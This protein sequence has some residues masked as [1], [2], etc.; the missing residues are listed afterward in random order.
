MATQSEVLAKFGE[1]YKALPNYPASD[2]P[3]R[4]V[5]A[6]ALVVLEKMKKTISLDLNDFLAASK[7]QISGVSA[8]AVQ[9]I[10]AYFGET[11]KFLREGGRTNRGTPKAINDMLNA[12]RQANIGTMSEVERIESLSAMQRYLVER[13]QE[14]HTRKRIEWVYDPSQSTWQI[15][16][17]ILEA[18]KTTG[19]EGPVAQYL[20]GAK[21]QLRFPDLEIGNESYSTA[22]VQLGRQ[23]DFFLG[24]TAF[25]VTVQPLPGVFD[26]CRRNLEQ[27]YRSYLLVPDR[28]LQASRQMAESFNVEHV[29]VQSIEN[30]V[31][32]NIDEIAEFSS[33]ALSSNLKALL[34]L[35]NKRVD[36]TEV[37]K[38]FLIE[39][40]AQLSL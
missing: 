2:G 12:L 31:G 20:V 35:Y 7:G 39:L 27:G 26:K 6:A 33:D 17:V 1:W 19:K 11:R 3:A 13:I 14:Y 25:H 5:I 28:I 32:Q 34:T 18:A 4:G 21:L 38:S 37:D 8:T 16:S 10:L 22:D 9:R 30:F 36:A 24:K 23:G 29:S 15:I 40:P